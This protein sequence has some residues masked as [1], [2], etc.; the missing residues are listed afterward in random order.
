MIDF[1]YRPKNQHINEAEWQELNAL[2]EQWRSDLSFYA[3]DLK[4]LQ[5]IIERNFLKLSKKDDIDLVQDMK[6]SLIE[7]NKDCGALQ[8]RVQKHLHYLGKLLDGPFK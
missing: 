5:R 4:Y 6:L 3:D 7:M 1:V 2:T 8:H